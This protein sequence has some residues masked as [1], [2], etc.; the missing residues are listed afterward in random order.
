MPEEFVVNFILEQNPQETATFTLKENRINAGFALTPVE[1]DHEALYNRE[2][3]DQHPI[4]AITGLAEALAQAEDKNFIFEQGIASDTWVI[5]HNLNKKPSITVVDS[6]DTLILGFE[7]DYDG[8]DKVTIRFNGAFTG[9]A[10]L[11]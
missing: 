11:N 9:K 1:R 3:A 10:Y 7:A 2:K 4:G 8:M 5:E 6:A